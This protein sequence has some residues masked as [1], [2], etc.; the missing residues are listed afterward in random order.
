[1]KVNNTTKSTKTKYAFIWNKNRSF[2]CSPLIPID[3]QQR[4]TDY[5][6]QINNNNNDQ[7]LIMYI[8]QLTNKEAQDLN[9]RLD[10]DP[11]TIFVE[12]WKKGR[13]TEV[14]CITT[15]MENGEVKTI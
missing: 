4:I 13:L 7:S 1:M 6:L 12:L 10:I 8:C 5:K 11:A 9:E 2:F 14:T 3:D 15:T